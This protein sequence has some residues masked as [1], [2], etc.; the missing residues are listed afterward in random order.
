MIPDFGDLQYNLSQIY[1]ALHDKEHGDG[2]PLPL[3]V[4]RSSNKTYVG[5]KENWKGKFEEKWGHIWSLFLPT[6][7]PPSLEAV[8]KSILN[9]SFNAAVRQVFRGRQKRIYTHIKKKP[10]LQEE[11]EQQKRYEKFLSEE[12][13][14]S[15]DE[16]NPVYLK[17]FENR[18]FGPPSEEEN[19]KHRHLTIDF[20][21]A[22]HVFWSIFFDDNKQH[23]HFC[24]RLE[25][26]I[27]KKSAALTDL[28][29]FNALKR[30]GIWINMEGE[31][32]HSIP[33]TLLSKLHDP[34]LLS[35]QEKKDF[36]SWVELFNNYQQK[37]SLGS[38]STVLKEA[39]RILELQGSSTLTMQ[40]L[41]YW[42]DKQ[43]CSLLKR[44]DAD[45]MRWRERLGPEKNPRSENMITCNGKVFILGKL[46]SPVKEIDDQFKV[47]ELK[48][49]ENWV[50]KIANNSFRL[51]IEQKKS[52]MEEEH[53]G[54]RF[55]EAI[56]LDFDGRCVIQERLT[57]FLSAHEWKSKGPKLTEVEERI[58]LI[59]ANHLYYMMMGGINGEDLSLDCL[60]LN[61]EG[62]LK[63]T[64]LLKMGLP[65]YN[66]WEEHCLKFSKGNVFVLNFLMHVS[67]LSQHKIGAY[68]RE[69]VKHALKTGK[70]D[71]GSRA[72]PTEHQEH[73]Q[74]AENY[75]KRA[76][77]LCGK[78]GK[79]LQLRELSLK[80]A[81]AQLQQKDYPHL[82]GKD[83]P[84][85]IGEKLVYFYDASPTPGIL[86]DQ[87]V[88]QAVKAVLDHKWKETVLENHS[89]YYQEKFNLM[90][91]FNEAAIA[92]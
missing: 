31:M 8:L 59:F 28:P 76:K 47:F 43:G 21:Q 71:L 11:L 32:H 9:E 46:L 5:Y 22:T 58:A 3:V 84:E 19:S 39:V 79:A 77:E 55:V 54:V 26:F 33:V 56:E 38:L 52:Q 27:D 18:S 80:H 42:L 66:E 82:T 30:E 29:F 12:L 65:N 90:M 75:H 57:S 23:K 78:N 88:H 6:E 48:G 50:V 62:M 17:D 86:S 91:S 74:G 53:C 85:L 63:S 37:I 2:K 41:L 81:T 4:F 87:I 51:L 64:K 72:L 24:K 49:H 70:T 44:D 25:P 89:A 35:V 61:S 68:Y 10:T 1:E 83:L 67:Q 73:N 40:D 15:I 36:K 13:K 14:G 69:A 20:H 45:H 60:G 7:N 16:A 34:A 92:E